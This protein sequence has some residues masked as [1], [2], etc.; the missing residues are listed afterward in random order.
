MCAGLLTDGKP[1][2]YAHN[3]FSPEDKDWKFGNF[4][5]TKETDILSK[6]VQST[7]REYKEKRKL[8]SPF[9]KKKDNNNAPT[10]NKKV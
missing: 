4:D 7:K 2:I 6:K 3:L 10:Q 8:K 5:F 1:I 9:I